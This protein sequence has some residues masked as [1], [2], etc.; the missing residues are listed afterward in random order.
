MVV[1]AEPR[2]SRG[3][4]SVEAQARYAF[5]RDLLVRAH[6][7]PADVVEF[8]AAPGDQIAALADM[9]YRC[10]ALDI[11]TS[12]AGWGSGEEGRMEHILANAGVRYIQWDLETTPYPLADC[13]FDA[14][15]MTE[16][17]EHLRDYPLLALREC[18]RV[19]RPGGRLYFTTPNSAYIVNRARL[20]LGRSVYTPLIDWKF[21]VPHARHAREYTFDEIAE[22]MADAGLLVEE[23]LSRHFHR[24]AGR[25]SLSARVA[26]RLIDRMARLRPTVGPSIVVARRP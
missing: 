20:L 12:A 24:E 5:V 15:V 8:G 6:P 1:S 4:S 7:A 13:S 21:G 10:T 11:G 18:Q 22:L 26:K 25:R 2:F 17:F 9:R 19:L 16:V 3:G 23:T 14:V